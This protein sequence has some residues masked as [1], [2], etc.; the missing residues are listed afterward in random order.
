MHLAA[1]VRWWRHYRLTAS[2]LGFGLSARRMQ[3][4]NALVFINP[5][6][7]GR[8]GCRLSSVRLQTGQGT[9]SP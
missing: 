3:A 8:Y 4:S 1:K 6:L 2:Y 9:G 7:D 5:Q